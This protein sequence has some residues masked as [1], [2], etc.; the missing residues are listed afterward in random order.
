MYTYFSSHTLI[1]QTQLIHACRPV[2]LSS[3]TMDVIPMNPCSVLEKGAILHVQH[4][5][6]NLGLR[7]LFCIYHKI[8]DKI[9]FDSVAYARGQMW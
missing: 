8:N 9:L 4:V 2:Q 7:N 6:G 3:Q 1:S 5:M